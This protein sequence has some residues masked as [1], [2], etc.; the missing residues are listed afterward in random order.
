M[1]KIFGIALVF[2][3]VASM[4]GSLPELR[5]SWYRHKEEAKSIF[6]DFSLE[7][8]LCWGCSREEGKHY[9]VL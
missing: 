6:R 5:R 8:L 7:F 1:G 9:R 4:L 2:A 3:M